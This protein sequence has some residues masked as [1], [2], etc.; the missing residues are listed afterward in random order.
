MEAAM[1]R[2][3]VDMIIVTILIV[4]A[5]I[6]VAFALLR[7]RRPYGSSPRGQITNNFKQIT[8]A[9]HNY[10]DVHGA[11][12]PPAIYSKDGKP[13]LS[14]RVAILPYIEEEAI[15]KQFK[16]DQPW[17]SP[18]NLSLL[19]KMS[20]IYD[21]DSPTKRPPGMTTFRVFVGPGTPFEGPRGISF[22]E[23]P[24]GTSSTLLVV[25]AAEAV[26]WTKPAELAYGPECA[27]PPLG[28]RFPKLFIAGFGD[29]SVRSIEQPVAEE[30]LRAAVTRNGAEKLGP[31]E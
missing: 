18:A 1:R 24:D 3:R 16:L 23:F 22:K 21:D 12:P 2:Y 17:D 20:R 8:L 6:A 13:L 26:P 15:Y 28:G 29:A 25:E 27:L 30:H 19:P 5:E 9:M 11:L 4:L 31:L 14:W 7:P 10:A